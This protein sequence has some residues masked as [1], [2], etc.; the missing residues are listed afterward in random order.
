MFRIRVVVSTLCYWLCTVGFGSALT[1][2]DGCDWMSLGWAGLLVEVDVCIF[3]F[4]GVWRRHSGFW[5]WHGV[6]VPGR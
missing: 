4:V 6:R 5:S 2:M 3:S 1:T